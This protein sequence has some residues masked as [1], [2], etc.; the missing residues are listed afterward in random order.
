M[1]QQQ[2][3]RRS[4]GRPC[5]R[6]EGMLR[7]RRTKAKAAAASGAVEADKA[8]AP[9]RQREKRKEEEGSKSDAAQQDKKA[10]APQGRQHECLR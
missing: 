4:S 8:H 6:T 9:T 3:S 5:R 7:S 10:E 1:K 2:G